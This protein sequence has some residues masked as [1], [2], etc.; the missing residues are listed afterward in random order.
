MWAGVVPG[1]GREEDVA[2][3]V[4]L[5]IPTKNRSDLLIRLLRYYRD[6]DFQ[7][8][9]CIG[10][11]SDPSHVERTKEGIKALQG[12]LKIIYQE[13]PG[14]NITQCLK[15]LI[16]LAPTRYAAA[17]MDDDFLV[18]S[19]LQRCALFLEA[20]PEYVAAHGV[21]ALFSLKSGAAYGP[22]E[23]VGYYRQP[24]IEGESAS[25]RLTD[26]LGKDAGTLFSMHRV[27]SWRSMFRD[28]SLAADRAISEE[29]L[30]SCMSVIQGKVKE[31]DCLYLLRQVHDRRAFHLDV[32]DQLTSPNWFQSYQV[33]RECLSEELVQQDGISV[34]EARRVV[35][36]ALWFY[37]AGGLAEGQDGSGPRSRWREG[38]RRIP[39]LRWGWRQVRSFL[40]GKQHRVSLPALLRTSSPYHADFMPVYRAVT[41][42]GL[43]R[44]MASVR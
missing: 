43:P 29:L 34:D 22:I 25:Q 24:V 3:K 40:P 15:G 27:E 12:K 32:F 2:S 17:V 33:F 6:L 1:L 18:P 31:L 21:A 20:H 44:G 14:L 11:S 23:G 16:D 42:P 35:K 39:A 8:C 30:P 5:L 36:R 41:T 38:A 7:G 10:D 19:S 37:L 9:I 26:H 13:I 4:T 28:A